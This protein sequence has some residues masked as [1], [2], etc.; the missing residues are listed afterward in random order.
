MTSRLKWI[1]PF[2]LY[3]IYSAAR[4]DLRVEHFLMIAAVTAFVVIGP[5]TRALLP[6][7]YPFALVGLLYDAM[8]PYQTLGVSESRVLLCDLR[9]VE[10]RFFGSGGATLHDFFLTHH[11]PALDLFCA[12]PYATFV[13]WCIGGAVWLYVK[14]RP[15]M[16]RFAWG[17]LLLN[18]M[19]FVT[20]HALPAAPPWYFHARGCVVD[21]ATRPSEGP[22][23]ARV[24]ALLGIS[25]FHGMYAKASSVFGALPSLHCA[26]PLLL[27]I[28]GWRSFGPRLR[29]AA[30]AYWLVMVFSAIYLDHHWVLDALLGSTYAVLASLLM[31]VPRLS[32]IRHEVHA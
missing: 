11:T 23:L 31:R 25:Y 10:S 21:L 27:V 16:L 7:L 17:F 1:A 3:A 6:G 5:R 4:S 28:E 18:V 22:A 15:A 24:D 9:A 19:G 20:Y 8:R 29:T 12:V 13:L 32:P 14:D 30:V 26:Y 2:V